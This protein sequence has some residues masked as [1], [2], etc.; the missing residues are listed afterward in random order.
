MVTYVVTFVIC[1]PC[2]VCYDLNMKTLLVVILLTVGAIGQSVN[3][4]CNT[5]G[6]VTNCTSNTNQ[7]YNQ[8][9]QAAREGG[10]GGGSLVASLILRHQNKKHATE[11]A[12]V[13]YLYCVNNTNGSANGLSCPVYVAKVNAF[14]EVKTKENLCKWVARGGGPEK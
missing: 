7:R 13:N 4:T 2:G 6:T 12:K 10:A 9:M 14:C 8:D 5:V 3:T 1:T 11:E